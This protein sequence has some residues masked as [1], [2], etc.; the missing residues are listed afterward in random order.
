[1]TSGENVS[2]PG[3]A[4]RITWPGSDIG[5]DDKLGDSARIT[6]PGSNIGSDS[7]P[8]DAA[9]ITQPGSDIGAGTQP[10][11]VAPLLLYIDASTNRLPSNNGFIAASIT[12]QLQ[13]GHVY[14]LPKETLH[15]G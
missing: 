5:V 8:S 2:Q 11:D 3:Y 10:N 14:P 9:R 13:H 4:G 12:T 15:H 6:P 1:M 7:Q